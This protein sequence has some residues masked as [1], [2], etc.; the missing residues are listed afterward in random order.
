MAPKRIEEFANKAFDALRAGI[1]VLLIDLFPPGRHDPH[2]MHDVIRQLLEDSDEP[3]DLPADEPLT[4]ASYVA[5]RPVEIYLEHLAPGGS[6]AEMPLFLNPERYVSVPLES[7]Y[8]AAWRGMP[9]FWRNV[10]E[11]QTS[12][13]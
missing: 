12:P 8:A 9:G 11:G 6:L 5:D 3:Y 7:T 1:H 4:L 2:G 10:L 13:S